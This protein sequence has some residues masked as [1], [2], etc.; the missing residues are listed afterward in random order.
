[1]TLEDISRRPW[2]ENWLEAARQALEAAIKILVGNIYPGSG[3]TFG[4]NTWRMSSS[5]A[6]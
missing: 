1:M 2:Q 3:K 6:A 4:A 5:A